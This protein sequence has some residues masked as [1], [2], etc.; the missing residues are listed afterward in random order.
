[1][2]KKIEQFVDNWI[3]Y[4]EIAE[5]VPW[6]DDY[7]PYIFEVIDWAFSNHAERLWQFILAVYRRKP[8][9]KVIGNLAAGPLEDLLGKFG[10]KFIERVIALARSDKDFKFLL[11]GVWQNDMPEEIWQMIQAVRNEL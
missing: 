9:Q 11:G 4:N 10:H 6:R 5:D 3:K 7:W 8:S 1:M 2:C